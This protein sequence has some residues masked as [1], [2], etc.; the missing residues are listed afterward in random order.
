MSILGGITTIARPVVGAITCIAINGYF[1]AQPITTELKIAG[2][3]SLSVLALLSFR[4]GIADFPE[5]LG[6]FEL[7]WSRTGPE[8]DSRM[9]S[10]R[11]SLRGP[12][13]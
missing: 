8:G 4:K 12:K 7:F 9:R 11:T 13:G 2:T 6:S 3:G 1:V 10:H 5:D